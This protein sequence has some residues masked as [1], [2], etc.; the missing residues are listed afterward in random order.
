VH[1]RSLRGRLERLVPRENLAGWLYGTV[2]VSSLL[3][4]LDDYTGS[5]STTIFWIAVTTVVFALAH[6]WAVAVEHSAGMRQVLGMAALRK[7]MRQEWSIVEAAA[8]AIVVLLLAVL[9]VLSKNQ[10]VTIALITNTVLLAAW[11]AGLRQL[12][13]G[14]PRQLVTS[15]LT[16]S[17]FGIVLIVLKIVVH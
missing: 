11:G 6:G 16:C 7:G 1:R 5:A 9:G 14:T 15:A 3:V 8:P 4:T 17:A 10:A 12:S 2:L 13:G